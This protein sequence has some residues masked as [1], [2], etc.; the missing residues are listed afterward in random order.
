MKKKKLIVSLEN[1]DM[2]LATNCVFNQNK[3]VDKP[4]IYVRLNCSLRKE[5]KDISEVTYEKGNSFYININ[6]N[7][8]FKL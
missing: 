5:T 3:N 2:A 4:I 8:N 7:N 1:K 6:I